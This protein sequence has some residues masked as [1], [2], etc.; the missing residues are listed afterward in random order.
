MSVSSEL[1]LIAFLV[2]MVIALLAQRNRWRPL[3]G[4]AA[5][6]LYGVVLTIGAVGAL[7]ALVIVALLVANR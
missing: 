5:Q 1:G 6:I 7:G 4:R 2:I 3:R